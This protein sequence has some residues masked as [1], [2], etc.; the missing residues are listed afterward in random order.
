M[1]IVSGSGLRSSFDDGLHQLLM[2]RSPLLFLDWA[3][4][5]ESSNDMF[6][7]SL[8]LGYLATGILKL[9]LHDAL[10]KLAGQRNIAT[11]VP[12]SSRIFQELYS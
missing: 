8:N 7:S 2:I 1:R 3:V 9:G 4:L 12:P 6:Y 5:E 10:S 11:T